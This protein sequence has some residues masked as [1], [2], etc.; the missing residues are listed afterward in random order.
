MKFFLII[1]VLFLCNCAGTNYN[2]TALDE[3]RSLK[4]Q[5]NILTSRVNDLE[6]SRMLDTTIV[7]GFDDTLLGVRR[8]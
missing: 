7:K 2:A 6:T 3:I 4:E 5:I 1:I 8:K